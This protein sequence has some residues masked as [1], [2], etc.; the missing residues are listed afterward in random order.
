MK[1]NGPGCSKEKRPC[2]PPVVEE[3]KIVVEEPKTIQPKRVR[4]SS[5]TKKNS[6]TDNKTKSTNV[7]NPIRNKTRR[8]AVR[9]Y[10]LRNNSEQQQKEQGIKDFITNWD[11]SMRGSFSRGGG[12]KTRRKQKCKRKMQRRGKRGKKTRRLR[13]Y[14]KHSVGGATEQ[15]RLNELLQNAKKKGNRK[16][17]E[18]LLEKGAKDDD[19][20]YNQVRA[21]Y[22][23]LQTE[24]GDDAPYNSV[25]GATFEQIGRAAA[26][27]THSDKNYKVLSNI[28]H[29]KDKN[30]HKRGHNRFAKNN[31][32][33]DAAEKILHSN[34]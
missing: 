27:R 23:H 2:S 12:A 11:P 1:G 22:N 20:I 3:P 10:N 28:V 13:R 9:S 14:A 18:L 26:I 4:F 7:I 19:D 17:I 21:S 31:G 30:P 32:F 6:K 5:E 33:D 16:L 8:K 29:S 34:K 15:E 24:P 25:G